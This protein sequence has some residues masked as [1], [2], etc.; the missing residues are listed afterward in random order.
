MAYS[1]AVLQE[2][3]I[4]LGTGKLAEQFYTISIDKLLLLVSQNWP[5]CRVYTGIP[6]IPC[7]QGRLQKFGAQC[8]M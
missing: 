7:E 5:D 1:N 2:P 6:G 8:E 3:V 4:L